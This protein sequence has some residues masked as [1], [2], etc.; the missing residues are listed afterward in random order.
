MPGEKPK[1]VADE[2]KRRAKV[3]TGIMGYIEAHADA[4]RRLAN[5][6]RQR[7]CPV[8]MK[9]FWEVEAHKCPEVRDAG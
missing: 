5:G 4:K 6:E 2:V 7:R 9:W 8:C 3:G 1:H